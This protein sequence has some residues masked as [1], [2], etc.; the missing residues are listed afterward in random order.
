MC[1]GVNFQFFSLLC[2][3]VTAVP[4]H[5]L[6]FCTMSYFYWI[7]EKKDYKVLLERLGHVTVLITRSQSKVHYR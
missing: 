2:C 6:E 4:L 5:A 3:A 7:C 1:P